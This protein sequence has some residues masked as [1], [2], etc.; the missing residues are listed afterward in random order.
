MKSPIHSVKHINQNTP[1]TVA[2]GAI[3][4]VLAIEAVTSLSANLS[5]E[6]VEG[7]K[8]SAIYIEY[9]ITSDDAAQ[10]SMVISVE[11]VPA[12][13]TPMT[14]AQS[15]ALWSY[16]NKKNILYTAQGLT[17]PN[18]QSGLPFVRQWIKIPKGKQRFGLED[19]LYINISGISNGAVFCGMSI[20]K[21]YR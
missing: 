11:K 12:G 7:A 2:A 21:E 5:R 1:T 18:V 19:K 20:Y 13:A 17:P 16:P 6:V 10:G 3:N 14:Y 4:N 15:V 9:W 8:V